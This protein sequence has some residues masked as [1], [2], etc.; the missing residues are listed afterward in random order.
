MENNELKKIIAELIKEG[1]SLDEVQKTLDVEYGEKMTFFDL[2][3]LVSE[4]DDIDW[5]EEEEEKEATEETDNPDAKNVEE[6]SKQGGTVVEISKLTRPG[7]ALSGSVNFASG[8]SADWVLDQHGR[9][10][11]EKSVGEPT[12]DDL[13]EFQENLKTKLSGGGK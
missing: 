9:L 5:G 12:E 10:S 4:L 1:R 11:F 2:R 3:M 7:V 6:T 8:A 13:R